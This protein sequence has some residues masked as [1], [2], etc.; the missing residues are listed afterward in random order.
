MLVNC[1]IALIEEAGQ[2]LESHVVTALPP[3]CKQLILIGDHQQLR[4]SITTYHMGKNY[5]LDIS[6]FER[7]IKN[8]VPYTR[9]EEQHR[10]RP[11]I[12]KM[13][14]FHPLFSEKT[15]PF[16]YICPVFTKNFNF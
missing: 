9:L 6:L 10:M 13:K 1:K 14:R 12:A 15:K 7:L 8:N 2:V 5:G 4:P 3:N 16:F 11:E